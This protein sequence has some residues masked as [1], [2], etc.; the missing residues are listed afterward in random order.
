LGSGYGKEKDIKAGLAEG[1][2]LTQRAQ[3]L[4]HRGHGEEGNLA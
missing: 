3:R 4:E 2:D 1:A